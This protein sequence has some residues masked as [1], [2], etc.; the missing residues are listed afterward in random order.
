MTLL[1]RGDVAVVGYDVANDAFSIVIMADMNTADALYISERSVD[2]ATGNFFSPDPNE[3]TIAWTPPSNISAGAIVTF[4]ETSTNGLFNVYVN[5]VSAGTA[6]SQRADGTQT[7]NH[8]LA[9]DQIFIYQGDPGQTN[10]TTEPNWL[11]GFNVDP[12]TLATDPEGDWDTGH[13]VS[14]FDSYL[15]EELRTDNYAYAFYDADVAADVDIAGYYS[16]PTSAATAAQWRARFADAANWTFSSGVNFTPGS[17]PFSNTPI[18][19][20]AANQAPNVA[21]N[22][23][24]SLSE[25]GLDVVANG[26]LTTTDAE[27][28]AGSLT[29]TVTDAVDNGTLWVDADGSGTINGSEAAL[30]VNG[31]FTQA[32]I[33]SGLLKYQ[34]N[35]S[36]TTGDSF[37][38]SVSDGT[39][40]VTGQTF[41]F[42]VA[43]VN[44]A[45]TLGNLNGDTRIWSEATGGNT[46]IDQGSDATLVDP[47]SANLNGG[48]IT[49]AIT[50]G[51]LA[52][53][54]LSVG[55]VGLVNSSGG[56]ITHNGTVIGTVSGGDGATLVI[57]FTSA[58]VTPAM[59]QD[60]LRA[61]LYTNTSGDNP[62]AGV[63]NLT[64]T[65]TDGDG[66]TSNVAGVAIT[67]T[68]E[69][70]AP[71]ATSLPTDVT[72][73]EDTASNLDLSAVTISDPDS[74]SITVT[75][76]AGAGT[77][78]ASSGGS[79]TVGGSG[80][81]TL[82]LT[83]SAANIDA[84][85]NTASNVT[86]TGASNASGDNAT[87]LSVSANDGSG[88]V[89]LGTVNIDITG[90]NDQPSASGLP[91]DVTVTEDAASN[92][93]LSAVTISDPDSASITVTLAAGA[94]TLA[95]SSGGSVTVGGSG[96][97]TLTLTGSAANI[98]AFLNT[99][100][101]VTYTGASN[102]NGNNATTLSISADD[103]TGSVNLGTVNI[104]ITPVADAPAPQPD[105]F[106]LNETATVVNGDLFADNGSGADVNVDAP[107]SITAV[108]GLAGNVGSQITLASGALLTVRADGTFDYD[109]DGAFEDLPLGVTRDDSFTYQLNGGGSVTVTL[110]I[111]G[112][113]NRDVLT[114]TSGNDDLSAGAQD[115]TLS[116]DAGDDTLSGE[117]GN[118]SLYGGSGHDVLSGGSGDDRLEGGEGDDLHIVDSYGDL[119]F[120]AA[121]EGTDRVQVALRAWSIFSTLQ[122]EE[123]EGTNDAGQTLTGNTRANRIIG[124]NG[125]DWLVGSGGSDTLEGNGGHDTLDGGS[126]ANSLAGG[127]G[128]DVYIVSSASDIVTE[129]ADQGTD[130]IRTARATFSL[131]G[132]DHVENLI[133]TTAGPVNL[134]G[135]ALANLIQGNAAGR[136]TLTGGDGNDTL[137][138]LGGN[139]SLSGGAAS[140]HLIGGLGQ[141]T[142]AG[143]T[144][145]DHYVVESYGDVVTEAMDEGSDTIETGLTAYSIFG[146]AHVENLTGTNAAGQTLTGNVHANILIGAGGQDR[147]IGSG[148]DDTLEGNGGNDTLEGGSGSNSLTGGEGDDTYILSSA[149]DV[150]I[151][152]SDGG[153]D[154]VQTALGSYS[155]ALA[156]FVERLEGIGG[157]Q[158]LTGNTLDNTIIAGAGSDTLLGANGH[159]TLQ[160]GG[161]QDSLSGGFGD[162]HLDGGANAD[163]LTGGGGADVFIFSSTPMAGGS[164]D[165]IT[166]MVTGEDA[167]HLEAASFAD[168]V[169]GALG[170]DQFIA[171]ATGEADTADQ[172][173]LYNSVNGRLYFDADGNGAGGRILFAQ[174]DPGLAL[175]STD[176]TII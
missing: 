70:D 172:R 20:N 24:S 127:Q 5:G 52:E 92:L 16:G 27:S 6:V 90:V 159:D 100:S 130:E 135:N 136:D 160:G 131:A 50:G 74:A 120:E 112:V 94:G 91:T 106:A 170:A 143:G 133:S 88:S 53:D 55:A 69:N 47:D 123:L 158:T 85:L 154:T 141:D 34:H 41:S 79:V 84:F 89:S 10:S 15:P 166:D 146:L 169:A 122:V 124:A 108:N 99:A 2:P 8:T 132:I 145:D 103:G 9:G 45:P 66:G 76:A 11:F 25:G 114:G 62:T 116:G 147:L 59:A 40:T 98:D 31:S 32:Q 19:V 86:Y 107:R 14:G 168:L 149:G 115:D 117:G 161:G 137:R 48:T 144:G 129:L 30:G 121:G 139:D 71:S 105:D 96:T 156:S 125:N 118:D 61:I 104:D 162:D 33:N 171:N 113:D 82:T 157:H 111:T 44:D 119:V 153:T 142:M 22:A 37:T 67:V 163:T 54:R 4:S 128:D 36:E 68:A 93:D 167:I 101:N 35:G 58:L 49:V 151:E 57:T 140:D 23:G 7:W 1:N 12:A 72:V 77:L 51:S 28:G 63:R 13:T 87:T 65:V 97:G 42:T 46:G 80:T 165:T 29:Y 64:V 134:T 176:F 173:I 3:G 174:L 21:I 150:V 126:G 73:T 152:L 109:P 148:G 83:G 17:N 138:G 39:N 110:T 175:G 18:I 81:G 38:F 164:F 155:L 78:A 60:V 102:A 43:P 56:T 26:E 75:L 95:A